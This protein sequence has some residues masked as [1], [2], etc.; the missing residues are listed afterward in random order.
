MIL[1]AGAS[2]RLGGLVARQLLADNKPVRAMS[3]TPSSLAELQKLGAEIVVGDQRNPQ[4]LAT[5]CQGVDTVFT[6]THA[7][8]GK[9]DNGPHAVDDLGNRNL[10][11]AARAAGVDHY[12]FTSVMGARS[13]SP[14]DMFRYKYTTEQYL[15]ASGLSYTILRPAAFMETWVHVLGDPIVK[16]GRAMVFGRGKNPINFVSAKD[17]A[18]LAVLALGDPRAR[19]QV[20]EIGGPENVTEIRFVQLIQQVTGH[21]GKIQHIPL[22]MIRLMGIV[23]QP[24]NPAFSRQS[25]AGILMDT[26]DMTFDPTE[27]LKLFPM[28]LTH[29][30]EVLHKQFERVLARH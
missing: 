4:S 27:T 25:L 28:Q 14:V 21:T 8:T 3:R 9:G 26:E 24:I 5:A 22:P 30:E 19:G 13:D 23:T 2:G 15:R 16:N 11:D 29:L 18:R 6:A 12:M 1:I 7:F 10:I 17:V 20:I